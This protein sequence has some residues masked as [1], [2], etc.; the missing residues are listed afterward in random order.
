MYRA[1]RSWKFTFPVWSLEGREL[2]LVP[3]QLCARPCLSLLQP[4]ADTGSGLCASSVTLKGNELRS[5]SAKL[6]AE[7]HMASKWKQRS[8][9]QFAWLQTQSL[10]SFYSKSP[11]IPHQEADKEVPSEMLAREV[12]AELKTW[13][14]LSI[15]TSLTLGPSRLVWFRTKAQHWGSQDAKYTTSAIF[16]H[17]F[18]YYLISH[19]HM[20]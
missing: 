17:L 20:A 4:H 3:W 5:Q 6:F 15:I 19:I 12:G 8:K 1:S 14:L 13:C 9:F 10:C 16:S 7:A 11:S 2:K 18:W